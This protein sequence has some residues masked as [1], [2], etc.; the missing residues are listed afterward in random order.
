[1]TEKTRVARGSGHGARCRQRNPPPV[2]PLFS[3]ASGGLAPR[4]LRHLGHS[5]P[6]GF[7]KDG[8]G[9]PARAHT[10]CSALPASCRPI[11]VVSDVARPQFPLYEMGLSTLSTQ[12][13]WEGFW[14]QGSCLGLRGSPWGVGKPGPELLQDTPWAS[15]RAPYCLNADPTI[16]GP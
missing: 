2:F 14:S 9:P 10:G 11:W 8:L 5:S 7:G 4:L 12:H 15:R 3:E 13:C 16:T 1:M 6:G